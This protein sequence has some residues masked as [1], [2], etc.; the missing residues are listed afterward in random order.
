MLKSPASPPPGGGKPALTLEELSAFCRELALLARARVPLGP[1]LRSGAFASG[2]G[3]TRAAERLAALEEQGRTLPEA[4]AAESQT[5]PPAMHAVVE[6]GIATGRLSEALESIARSARAQA[7]TRAR[8]G[9]ALIYPAIL[10]ITASW[11]LGIFL[12]R[13]IAGVEGV[14]ATGTVAPPAWLAPLAAIADTAWIW[15]HIIPA[16]LLLCLIVWRIRGRGPATGASLVP[17][18]L[19]WIPGLRRIERNYRMGVLADF[20]ALLTSHGVPL[21]RAWVLAGEA[22]G[23]A[24][25]QAA[26]AHVAEAVSAGKLQ[27]AALQQSTVF[28]PLFYQ[29]VQSAERQGAISAAY[30]QLTETYF[31]QAQH[32]SLWAQTM[33]PVLLTVTLGMG[34]VMTYAAAVFVPV[35]QMIFDL[36]KQM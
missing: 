11:L 28:P 3:M 2:S 19:R 9:G 18:V 21:P 4:L 13:L 25:T 12:H 30:R 34:V 22:T 32:Q 24:P 8:V 26:A 16:V 7:E 17:L 31:R 20:L 29:I 27:S 6:S 10:L 36:I 33:L 14:Y 1:G 23:H 5:W 15:C 35:L